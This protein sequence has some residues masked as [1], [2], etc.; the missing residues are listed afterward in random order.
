MTVEEMYE[1]AASVTQVAGEIYKES[2]SNARIDMCIAQSWKLTAELCERLERIAVALEQ[3]PEPKFVDGNVV[4]CDYVGDFGKCSMPAGHENE[5]R[6]FVT[7]D[8]FAAIEKQRMG[9]ELAD[10]AAEYQKHQLAQ[11][12]NNA[13]EPLGGGE[14]VEPDLRR[15][16]GEIAPDGSKL[17]NYQSC[18]TD[19]ACLLSNGHD[20]YHAH[21]PY[22][23]CEP[24]HDWF[25][26]D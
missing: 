4:E 14:L 16:V 21:G 25:P 11:M 26:K 5:H 12:E 10:S 2:P 3:K 7:L 17:A 23:A 18:Q 13:F 15:R 1:L 6:R 24:L 19:S 8:E 9:R 22:E 20:G